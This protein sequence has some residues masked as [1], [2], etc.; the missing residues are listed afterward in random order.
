MSESP[1]NWKNEF[2][3]AFKELGP[4]YDFLGWKFLAAD[5]AVALRYPVFIP[6][7]LAQKIKAQ[8]PSGILA[9]QFLPDAAELDSALNAQGL[10]DPIGDREHQAAPQLIHRYDSRALFT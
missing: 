9:R 1:A 5:R 7:R 8:G 10:A 3:R 6:V 2:A 4:L